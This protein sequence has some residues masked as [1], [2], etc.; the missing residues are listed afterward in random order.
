M[1]GFVT[2]LDTERLGYGIIHLRGGRKQIH[3]KLD[4]SVGLEML[5]RLGDA[6]DKGQPLIRAFAKPENVAEI[7]RDLLAAIT[8]DDDRIEPPPL[9]VER[10]T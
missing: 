2:A 8:I 7:R 4:L 3:D 9:I 6:V 5:V 10:I 1:A